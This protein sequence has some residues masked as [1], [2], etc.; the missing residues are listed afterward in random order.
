MSD[1]RDDLLAAAA[2][3]FIAVGI[4]KTTMEDIAREARAGKAT[5]YRYFGNKEAVVDA[6]VEREAER[7]VGNV[8]AAA[9]S[10]DTTLDRLEAAFVAGVRFFV[11]HP[12]LTKGRDEEPGLILPRVTATGGPVVEAGL[13]LFAELVEEGMAA[14]D[15]RPVEPRPA[16]E[17]LLRLILSYFTFPPMVVAV[18]D[19]E[20]AR[21]FARSLVA[22]GL[23][24][25]PAAATT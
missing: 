13:A 5:L 17:M 10:H 3:R 15:L 2:R 11:R 9:Q 23:R 21:A 6:L 25:E 19:D 22:G 14:G 20:A 8:T 18:D 24:S 4:S 7:F 1:R 12:V 16:A